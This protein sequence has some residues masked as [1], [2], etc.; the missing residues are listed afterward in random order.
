MSGVKQ[1]NQDS[2]NRR[3]A[4][5]QQE[6]KAKK[7][8]RTT[9]IIIVVVV[10]LLVAAAVFLNS[11]LIRRTLTAVTVADRNFSAAEFDYFYNTS[12]QEYVQMANSEQYANMLPVPDDSKPLASQIDRKSVV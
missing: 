10:V 2:L 9:T 1:K 5:A 6:Y 7:K 12:Y 4:R 3:Q 11:K 8:L